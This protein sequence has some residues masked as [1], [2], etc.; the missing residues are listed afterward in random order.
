MASILSH[1]ESQHTHRQP[2][3][4]LA[5]AAAQI[6]DNSEYIE[7]RRIVCESRGNVLTISGRVPTYFLKQLAQASLLNHLEGQPRIENKL[8]VGVDR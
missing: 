1:F 3:I 2:A 8:Q 4:S 5:V 7:L 6:F